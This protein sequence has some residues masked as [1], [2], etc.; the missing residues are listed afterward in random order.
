VLDLSDPGDP[1]VAGSLTAPGF[2]DYLFPLSDGLLFGVG[3]DVDA[4]NH[5]GG[6][7][8]G[9]FDVSD[10]ARPKVLDTRSVGASG[11]QSALDWS[12]HGINWLQVG[13]VAR[14]G[15]PMLVTAAPFDPAP[16]HGLQR[17]AVDTQA[18]TLALEAMLPA[19]AGAMT[20]PSLSG[21]RSLQIGSKL[22]Y[23]TGGQ[24]VVADW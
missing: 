16:Q 12:S 7:K 19:P 18:Q 20:Y 13:N 2:S 22:V 15:L 1:H 11:S 9:L 23:L 14:I 5:L 21:D 8:L 3:H 6:V 10:P 4:S 24:L 17:I